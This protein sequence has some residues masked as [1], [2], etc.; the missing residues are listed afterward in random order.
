MFTLGNFLIWNKSRTKCCLNHCWNS[1]ISVYIGNS[2]L[3]AL[4]QQTIFSSPN[5]LI[6]FVLYCLFTTD[7]TK[8]NFS[9]PRISLYQVSTVQEMHNDF[10]SVAT[11]ISYNTLFRMMIWCTFLNTITIFRSVAIH[12]SSEIVL[13]NN[14]NCLECSAGGGLRHIFKNP[15]SKDFPQNFNNGVGV[16]SWSWLTAELTSK[17]KKKIFDL[18]WWGDHFTLE[19]I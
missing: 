2:I 5:E 13:Y 15:T 8:P 1:N 12:I 17:K 16:L 3:K 4:M 9:V 6:C 14:V 10:P 11:H 7:I 19:T 18:Q